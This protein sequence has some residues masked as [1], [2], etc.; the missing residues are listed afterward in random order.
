M[1]E[2]S[3]LLNL[4]RRSRRGGVVSF[5]KTDVKSVWYVLWQES[6][7][8][9]RRL[10]LI[11]LSL[12]VSPTN[13]YFFRIGH[14]RERKEKI[15]WLEIGMQNL[16]A[17][18]K[19]RGW[20]AY[21]VPDGSQEGCPSET[22]NKTEN[23]PAAGFRHCLIFHWGPCCQ[24]KKGY[25]HNEIQ[26]THSKKRMPLLIAKKGWWVFWGMLEQ[27][28]QVCGNQTD[29]PSI[30]VPFGGPALESVEH[31]LSSWR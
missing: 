7:L 23:S 25:R 20:Q 16:C 29:W 21:F 14:V 31:S 11:P 8:S 15:F 13:C 2:N 26:I 24:S 6:L 3:A 10:G 12:R 22:R 5:F 9:V 18:P 27:K 30:I 17:I 1:T 4:S 19:L 28:Y